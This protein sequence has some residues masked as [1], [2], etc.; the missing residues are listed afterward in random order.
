[1]M[2][3][4][5]GCCLCLGLCRLILCLLPPCSRNLCWVRIGN[6]PCLVLLHKAVQTTEGVFLAVLGQLQAVLVLTPPLLPGRQQLCCLL[7]QLA[8]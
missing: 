8:L 4:H 5:H 2:R 3:T 1:M 7:V 6:G